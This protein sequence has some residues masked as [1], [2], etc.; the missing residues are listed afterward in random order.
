MWNVVWKN[1]WYRAIF[2]SGDSSATAEKE[3][4]PLPLP[5]VT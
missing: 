5:S 1:A 4:V 2:W 3:P